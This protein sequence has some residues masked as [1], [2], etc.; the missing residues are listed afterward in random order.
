MINN[1][2]MTLYSKPT[3]IT[4]F[5]SKNVKCS[6]YIMFKFKK[7]LCLYLSSYS[8]KEMFSIRLENNKTIVFSD[9]ILN[10]DNTV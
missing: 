9:N 10:I 4:F 8:L 2:F 7:S 3:K 6:R 5:F 1:D